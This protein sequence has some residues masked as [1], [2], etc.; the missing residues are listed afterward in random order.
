[1]TDPVAPGV[2][3]FDDSNSYWVATIPAMHRRTAVT[4]PSWNSVKVPNTGTSIRI[5][6]VTPGGFMQ[7]QVTPPGK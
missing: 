2:S 5:T 3:T 6:S 4:R 7:V 1:M